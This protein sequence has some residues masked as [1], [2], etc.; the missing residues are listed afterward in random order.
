MAPQRENR[1]KISAQLL[2]VRHK[3]TEVANLVGVSRT[4][5][6]AIKK[7]MDDGECVNKR[8]GSGRKTVVDRDSLRVTIYNSLF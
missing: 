8:A 1:V 4:I 6:Y 5:V 7:L 3:V 2:R